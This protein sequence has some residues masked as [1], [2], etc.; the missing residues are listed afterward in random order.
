[1]TEHKKP[2]EAMFDEAMCLR[3]A[4]DLLGARSLL[5]QLI[6]QIDSSS[7]ALLGYSHMQF[8]L[9]AELH[10][11]QQEREHRF[12]M[13]VEILPRHELASVCLF[14]AL[15]MGGRRAR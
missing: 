14:G 1:M 5:T 9:I 13:A 6:Q 12:K 15:F 4:D 10:G 7:E 2:F 3:D 11:D 8:G